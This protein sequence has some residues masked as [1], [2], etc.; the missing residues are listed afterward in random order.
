MIALKVWENAGI[1]HEVINSGCS[2]SWFAGLGE[3]LFT[4]Y[5]G[6]LG[7]TVKNCC[8]QCITGYNAAYLPLFNTCNQNLGSYRTV[9][10]V[11]N[12]KTDQISPNIFSQSCC[13][14]ARTWVDVDEQQSTSCFI[15]YLVFRRVVFVIFRSDDVL[16]K[17]FCHFVKR[18]NNALSL[19]KY[20]IGA[21]IKK[22]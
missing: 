18:K 21:K 6:Q 9:A 7:N 2:P 14:A 5:N 15:Y 4:I 11:E 3:W 1:S 10:L 8:N 20:S 19:W 22:Q 17:F 12:I 13:S 16:L